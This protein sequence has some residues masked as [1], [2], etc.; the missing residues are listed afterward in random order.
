MPRH[1]KNCRAAKEIEREIDR[2]HVAIINRSCSARCVMQAECTWTLMATVKLRSFRDNDDHCRP[3]DQSELHGTCPPSPNMMMM[4]FTSIGNFRQIII[5]RIPV[6][7]VWLF[8]EGELWAPGTL[9]TPFIMHET[10]RNG[11]THNRRVGICHITLTYLNQHT[12]RD[13]YKCSVRASCAKTLLFYS[14]HNCV[15]TKHS[16]MNEHTS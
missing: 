10:E 2:D 12:I 3:P 16:S 9:L 13:P 7:Y 15:I 14:G 6:N 4:M 11:C 1:R 8:D 5:T